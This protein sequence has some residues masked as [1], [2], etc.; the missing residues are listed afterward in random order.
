MP[1][2]FFELTC[3]SVDL[4]WL[5]RFI[6]PKWDPRLLVTQFYHDFQTKLGKFSK[7][8]SNDSR[9]CIWKTMQYLSH[10]LNPFLSSFFFRLVYIPIGDLI[11]YFTCSKDVYITYME[12][13]CMCFQC[14][15]GKTWK[16]RENLN[17]LIIYMVRDRL[18]A[19]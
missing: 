11:S 12:E 15:S 5:L 18:T 16:S 10:L 4:E 19:K 7:R 14:L 9:E 6:T 3:L 17:Y 13:T 1:I 8:F 2:A